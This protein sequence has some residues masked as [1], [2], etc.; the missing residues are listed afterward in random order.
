MTDRAGKGRLIALAGNPNVG[1][2]TLQRADRPA[3]AH[4]KLAGEDRCAGAGDIYL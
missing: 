2:S 1:K 3:A 4:R